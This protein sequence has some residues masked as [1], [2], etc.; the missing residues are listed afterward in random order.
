MLRKRRP[1]VWIDGKPTMQYEPWTR[2]VATIRDGLADD[3]EA[4]AAFEAEHEAFLAEERRLQ[5]LCAEHVGW[6]EYT[7]HPPPELR[8][9]MELEVAYQRWLQNRMP[10]RYRTDPQVVKRQVIIMTVA[11]LG[12]IGLLIAY[13]VARDR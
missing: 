9:M 3:P 5:V 7:Y 8:E 1:L 6:R 10:G 13:V 12:V 4:L 11:A 2:H